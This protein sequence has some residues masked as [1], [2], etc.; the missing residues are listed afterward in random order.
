M[1]FPIAAAPALLRGGAAAVRGLAARVLGSLLYALV[2]PVWWAGTWRRR[3]AAEQV[4][5]YELV[6]AL[7]PVVMVMR[8]RAFLRALIFC[9]EPS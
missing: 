3:R 6:D 9:E 8:V 7:G 1:K 2:Y 4:F 5:G